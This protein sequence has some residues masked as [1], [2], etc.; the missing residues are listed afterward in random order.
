MEIVMSKI[1]LFFFWGGGGGGIF[2]GKKCRVLFKSKFLGY[3]LIFKFNL[4]FDSLSQTK[5][6]TF[7]IIKQSM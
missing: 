1:F 2:S 5:V 3:Y 4:N 7:Y 6:V